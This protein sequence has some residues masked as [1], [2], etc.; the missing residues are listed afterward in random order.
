M[1][2]INI[3]GSSLNGKFNTYDLHQQYPSNTGFSIETFGGDDHITLS[4]IGRS[5][6]DFVN[7][8]DGD[9]RMVLHPAYKQ[10]P[11]HSYTTFFGSYGTD[12]IHIPDGLLGARG[13][14]VDDSIVNFDI[15]SNDSYELVDVSVSSTVESIMIDELTYLTEDIFNGRIRPVDFDERY[16]RTYGKTADWD[17]YQLDTYTEYYSQTPRPLPII[18]PASSR[19]EFNGNKKE[20]FLTGSRSVDYIDGGK[21]DDTIFG[22]EGDDII[23]GGK[24]SDTIYTGDGADMIVMSKKL[25]KGSKNFDV[26][27]DFTKGEDYLLIEDKKIKSM[28][29]KAISRLIVIPL[30]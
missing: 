6:V 29:L 10:G 14:V 26:L 16:F 30:A 11:I 28:S 3:N 27:M 2:Q 8:G 25:G 7:A 17:L 5:G 19:G 1:A 18:V 15:Y 22:L 24:G 9:D 21:G 20:N 4:L 23:K 13:F 12:H